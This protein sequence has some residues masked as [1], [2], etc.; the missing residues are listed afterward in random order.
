MIFLIGVVLLLI[1]FFFMPVA[2]ALSPDDEPPLWVHEWGGV[3]TVTTMLA[4]L[5]C[6][7]IGALALLA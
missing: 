6:L 3:I 5:V 1:G 2:F 4:G 7:V